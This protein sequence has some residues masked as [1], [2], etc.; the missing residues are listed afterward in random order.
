MVTKVDSASIKKTSQGAR[1]VD[2]V[3]LEFITRGQPTDKFIGSISYDY[4]KFGIIFR[5]TRF[6]KIVDPTATLSTADPATG[7]KY[8]TF[9]AKTLY[10]VALTFRPIQKMS[11]MVGVNNMTDVYPDLLVNPQLANEVIYSRRTNQFGTQGRFLNAS[12]Q[13]N[14]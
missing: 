6:G 7:L 8:Q 3:A 11:I 13:Y 4:K 5:A 10:D 9:G 12:V 1:V 14:F 2:N